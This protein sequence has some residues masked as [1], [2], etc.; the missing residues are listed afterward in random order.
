MAEQG[1]RRRPRI[2]HAE[3]DKIKWGLPSR[4][5]EDTGDIRVPEWWRNEIVQGSGCRGI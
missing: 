3:E 2:P 5:E 1:G 4:P